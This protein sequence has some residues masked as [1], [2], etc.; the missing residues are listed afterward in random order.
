[1]P[2]KRR[3]LRTG[4]KQSLKLEVTILERLRAEVAH[5]ITLPTWLT[6][7]A[8]AIRCAPSKSRRVEKQIR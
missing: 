2:L 1:M 3:T 6:F 8:K 5:D 7:M 4:D